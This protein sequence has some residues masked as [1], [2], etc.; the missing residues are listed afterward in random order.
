MTGKLPDLAARDRGSADQFNK[1]GRKPWA[2]VNFITAHDG[3]TLH[4]LVSY[5]DK[6]NEAN[7]ED[8]R[9]GHSHNLSY[10]YGVEGPDRRS[11]DPGGAPAPDAQHAGD[12]VPVPGHADAARG[13]RVR[14]HAERQQQRL[15]PGQRDQLARLGRDRRGGARSRR[16]HPAPDH[17]AQRPA[18]PAPRPLPHRPVRRGARRQGRDVAAPGRQR[19]DAART[20]PTARPRAFAVH[21]RRARPG[22]RHCTAAAATRRC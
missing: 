20:G 5:N 14:P 10:N 17:P 7:G 11:R 9:D 13:R 15:L 2:S 4:D 3:F 21:A 16:I 22:H 8:N 6:H 1:R 19:D 18:D 12:A